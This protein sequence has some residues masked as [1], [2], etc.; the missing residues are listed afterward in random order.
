MKVV[1]SLF[2][3]PLF[4]VVLFINACG[5]GGGGGGG[6]AFRL[7]G[8]PVNGSFNPNSPSP[9]IFSFNVVEGTP[10]TVALVNT[11]GDTAL[12]VY[13]ANPLVDPSA[14]PI[15]ISWVDGNYEAVSFIASYS[16][17]VYALPI[18]T[19]LDVTTYTIEATTNNL[20]VGAAPRSDSVYG[21]G[22]F[23][24]DLFYSFDAQIGTTYEVRVTPTQ[25]NVD[26]ARVTLNADMTGSVGSSSNTGTATDSVFFS[27][28]AT[29]RYYIRIDGTNVDS[30]FGISVLEVPGGPDLNVV[31]DNAVSD[32][33]NVIV[34]YTVYN[35]GADAYA[36]DFQVDVWADSASLPTIGMTGND[37]ITHTA[38]NIAGLGG[39]LSGQVTI[40]NGA[41]N[42]TAYAVVDTLEA[43]VEG[44]ESNNVS[45]GVSW[46]KPLIVPVSIDFES[47]TIPAKVVMSGDTNWTIDGTTG[48]SSSATSLRSG[49]I[50]D[51]QSTCFA[52]SA[53]HNQSVSISFDR[54]VSSES[55]FDE[56]TFYI[57]N[58]SQNGWSG[59]VA[60]GN[61]SFTAASG[62]H[63]YKWCYAKD[64]SFSSGTDEAW[65]DNISIVAE[66]TDLSVS[67]TSVSSDGVNVT[68][69]YSV[70]NNTSI[71]VGAFS[72]DFWSD[73]V[74]APVVGDTGETSANQPSLAAWA[75]VTG[76]VTIANAAASGTAYAVVDT[77]NTVQETN[78]ANNVSSGSAWVI[79]AP[80][81]SVNITSASTDGSNV[82]IYYTVTN[83]GTGDSGAFDVDLWADSLSAPTVGSTGDTSVSYT[84]L[85]AGNTINDSVVIAN[86]SASGTSFA[87]VDTVDAIN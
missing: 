8:G 23:G 21:A 87:I 79:T 70:S 58:V 42:G 13:T 37:S 59:S 7:D 39:T 4:C 6:N 32:G 38:V 19:S 84:G 9:A 11:S 35:T 57:D 34:D 15:G 22:I 52:I 67:I 33:S 77:A 73:A 36:S 55:G 54:M 78:E 31:I 24:S 82:T 40:P 63:E 72:V 45:A 20:S 71:P 18:S 16:G 51:S 60:W 61:V 75:S 5:G 41:E 62:V 2:V 44:N 68:I 47:G 28:T 27:A 83:N 30:T 69:N 76:S 29:G 66:P 65:V 53:Y 81:L 17:A 12:Y 80:D 56:L 3:L 10:Y 46:E 26:L 50:G 74:S 14:L 85:T 43:V 48:G 1:K 64:F 86:A 49:N 25:G